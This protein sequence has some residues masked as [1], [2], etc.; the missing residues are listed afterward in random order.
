MTITHHTTL[1]GQEVSWQVDPAACASA[2]RW[3]ARRPEAL[4]ADL[5]GMAEFFPHWILVGA[6]GGRPARCAGCQELLAPREGQL[7]CLSCARAGAADG[8][9]W[10]GQIPALVRPEPRFAERRAALRAAGFEEVAAGGHEY[11][12]APLAVLYPDEW[13]N[14]EP[15]VRYAPRWLDALGLPRAS[16]AHHLI[17]VARACLYSY[18]QWRAEPV[19]AVLQQRVV[20]HLASLLK[21]AAGQSP[22]RAFIGR[23]HNDDW[24]PEAAD[25]A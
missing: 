3:A 12:L 2:S 20:N 6:Q 1:G 15:E 23:I 14:V 19:H 18:G 7:R 10:L 9:I 8:L 22:Q 4:R 17:G 24:R 11:L 16:A 5:E 13:P 21:I 25:G